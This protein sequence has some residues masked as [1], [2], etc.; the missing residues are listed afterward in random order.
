MQQRFDV[1]RAA[2]A[3]TLCEGNCTKAAD[4]VGCSYT[5]FLKYVN[6]D[7]TGL[8][9]LR[10][11]LKRQKGVG[12]VDEAKERKKVQKAV[13]VGDRHSDDVVYEALIEFDGSIPDAADAL[14]VDGNVLR[15]R[16]ARN[17]RLI[18]AMHEGEEYKMMLLEDEYKKIAAGEISVS[19]QRRQAIFDILKCK[20]GWSPKS[21][22]KHEGLTYD[23]ESVPLKNTEPDLP[24]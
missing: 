8:K 10:D 4:I 21:T 9:A 5:T 3:L 6:K 20:R 12:I 16:V 22:V 17:P 18:D 24:N 1:E 19:S 15:K 7:S 11:T 2:D 13:S 23:I 14:G